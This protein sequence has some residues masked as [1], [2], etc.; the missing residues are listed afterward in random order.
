MENKSHALAAGVFVLAVAAL[1]VALAMWLMRDVTN[2]VTYEMTTDASITGLQPQA[3]V[4]FKGVAVGKVTDI[5]LD[6]D[7]RGRV[8]VR[9]A[10]TP[11]APITRSTFATL[12]FQ[13][14]TGLSFVQLDDFGGSTEPPAPGPQG[15][16]PR[17]PLQDSALGQLPDRLT[18]LTAKL[19]QA[20]DNINL[21]LR[22]ENQTALSTML[23]ETAAAAK[24]LNQLAANANRALD[25]QLGPGRADLPA[26][27]RQTAS[28]LKSLQEAGD[29]AGAAMDAIS[30]AAADLH[31][32]LGALT[33]QGGAIERLSDSAAVINA[34]TLPRIQRLTQDAS[35]AVRRFDRAVDA[36]HENPQSL[37]YGPG[38][39]APG[40][41]EPGFTPPAH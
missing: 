37:I 13:G 5:R 31:Q 38:A 18:G 16:P 22:G 17:I 33:A 27:A 12:A 8:L 32:G 29:K 36:I 34:S 2:T 15:G 40:P 41:G 4:R 7:R 9:V 3:A 24:S 26:L 14:V 21:L 23:T 19:E 39:P 11:D 20:T 25:A 10:V 6:P 28:T 30:A 1:L 35:H